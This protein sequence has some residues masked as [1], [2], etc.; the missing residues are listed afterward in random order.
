MDPL[1]FDAT[2]PPASPPVCEAPGCG[3]GLTAAQV[4]RGAKACSAPCRARA[5]RAR[6]TAAVIARAVVIARLDALAVE[7][8]ALRAEVAGAPR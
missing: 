1:S 4:A 6:R 3:R 5:H 7:V 8:A 2:P